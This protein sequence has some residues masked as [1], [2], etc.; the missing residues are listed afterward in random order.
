MIIIMIDSLG[1]ALKA[2]LASACPAARQRARIHSTTVPLG[3]L[4]SC[5]DDLVV[6]LH[7]KHSFMTDSK[8]EY[9]CQPIH[10]DVSV[11][12]SGGNV[13]GSGIGSSS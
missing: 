12:A 8:D 3:S 4:F 11:V 2:W 6:M 13:G 10:G 1:C 5:S 9:D 7:E